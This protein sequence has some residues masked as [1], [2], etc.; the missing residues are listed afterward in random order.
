VT[1]RFNTINLPRNEQEWQDF[2]IALQGTESEFEQFGNYYTKDET[3]ALMDGKTDNGHG[4][5][6]TDVKSTDVTVYRDYLVPGTTLG[7]GANAPDLEVLMDDISLYAFAGTGVVVEEGFFSVHILHDLKA[8]TYPTFH[9][10]WT[11]GNASPVGNVKWHVS[12]VYANGYSAFQFPS[13]STKL[14]TVQAAGPQ[15]TH[16]ITPDDD[17]PVN[18]D[19]EPDGQLLCHIWRDPSDAEDTFADDAYLIGV[20]LHMEVG[21]LATIERN[22]PFTSAGFGT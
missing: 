17:M 7:T 12:Y 11:H 2:L 16:H 22:R 8:G 6:I 18:V 1:S 10:H 20:D 14:S 13:T 9:V 21:Q 4:H 5:E 3:D 19:M 15:Y